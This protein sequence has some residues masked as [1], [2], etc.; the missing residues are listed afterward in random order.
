MVYFLWETRPDTLVK[1]CWLFQRYTGVLLV[2]WAFLL[3]ALKAD[4]RDIYLSR[5]HLLLLSWEI[6]RVMTAIHFNH[7][8]RSNLFNSFWC[9]QSIGSLQELVLY[10]ASIFLPKVLS[11]AEQ[12]SYGDYRS[13]QLPAVVSF[14]VPEILVMPKCRRRTKRPLC[15]DMR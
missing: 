2:S 10:L 12:L 4:F 6:D 11:S 15:M 13:W 3:D 8:A 1:K 5:T 7:L 9:A 14:V